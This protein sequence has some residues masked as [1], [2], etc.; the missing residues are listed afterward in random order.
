MRL[1]RRAN[2][3]VSGFVSVRR[4]LR[5]RYV[6]VIFLIWS[7]FAVLV[8]SHFSQLGDNESYLT[9]AYDDS[10]QART[11]FITLI[12]SKILAMVGN[13]TITDIIFGAF[14]ALGVAYMVK[15]GQVHGRH[16]WPLLAIMLNPNFG[17][18]S[19]VVGREALFVCMLGFFMGSVLGYYQNRRAYFLIIALLCLAGMTF[20]RSAYGLGMGIFFIM[21]IIYTSRIRSRLGFG[22]QVLLFTLAMMV[23]L[24]ALYPY[25]DDYIRNDVLP[26]AKSY[27]TVASTTTRTWVSVNSTGELVRSLP[28]SLPLALMGPTP[29][30]VIARPVMF[31]F[32]LSGVLVLGVTIYS[33]FISFHRQASATVRKILILGWF[34]ATLFIIVSFVPFGIYNPGSGIRYE[35]CFLLF[36]VFPS[37]LYSVVDAGEHV[38]N[39][40]SPKN[41]SMMVS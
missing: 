10:G 17:V 13:E 16:R 31:P 39:V 28:W 2:V 20:I 37:M 8:Y 33:I 18:W 4:V 40:M 14:A 35:S 24:F 38:E 6:F 26:K 30:E 11:V 22:V 25:L 34:P 27:F 19:S 12:S 23:A 5:C 21:F 7:L 29:S 9:G 15:H 3:S 36:L 32:L 41:H 1:R